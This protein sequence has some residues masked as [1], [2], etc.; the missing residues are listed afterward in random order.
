MLE[1]L[2]QNEIT[3]RVLTLG[4]PDY[5]QD[6]GSREELLAEAALDASGIERSI[7]SFI[8]QDLA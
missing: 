2:A 8:K 1:C 6:H 7:E 4:L 3:T 5:F